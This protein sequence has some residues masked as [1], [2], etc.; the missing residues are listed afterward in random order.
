MWTPRATNANTTPSPELCQT[1]KR[2]APRVQPKLEKKDIFKGMTLL[3]INPRVVKGWE[4]SPTRVFSFVNASFLLQY[5]RSSFSTYFHLVTEEWVQK[6]QQPGSRQ[7]AQLVKEGKGLMHRKGVK[8]LHFAA[9]SVS[10]NAKLEMRKE[11]EIIKMGTLTFLL[12]W[13]SLNN[14]SL[15]ACS[16]KLSEERGDKDINNLWVQQ[17]ALTISQHTIDFS[18]QRAWK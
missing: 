4:T 13:T 18:F 6:C 11:W 14:V 10:R 12:L 17:H 1:N 15:S 8:P 16:E 3:K 9:C 7:A 5:Y 2:W